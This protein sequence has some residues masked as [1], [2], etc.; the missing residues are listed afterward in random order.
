MC[1]E[2][3]DLCKKKKRKKSTNFRI[4]HSI[5]KKREGRQK[6]GCRWRWLL[7]KPPPL[8]PIPPPPIEPERPR[9]SPSAPERREKKTF[10]FLSSSSLRQ[11]LLAIMPPATT[12]HSPVT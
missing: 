9:P 8:L 1:R 10:S 11:S 12:K 3:T 4:L 2:R 5:K 7:L 6:E